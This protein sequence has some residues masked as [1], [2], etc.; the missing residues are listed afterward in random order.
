MKVLLDTHIA[1]WAL[2]DSRELPQ[3]AREE[4]GYRFL[5]ITHQAILAYTELDH[6]K[7][8]FSH[9]D[10]FDRLLI[11]QA[12]SSGMLFIT[13]DAMLDVY[14]EPVVAIV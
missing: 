14:G 3:R 12:K 11:A 1:I 7:A 13:H 10:P 4:S 8:G 5:P 2:S 9:K 6:G